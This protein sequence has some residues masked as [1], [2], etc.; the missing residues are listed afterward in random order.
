MKKHLS[1]CA[2]KAGY[3]FSFDNGK[4]FD[5]QDRYKNFG[6][7]LFSIYYDFETTTGGVVFFDVCG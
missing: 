4:I 5:Y 3:I 7:L 2:G 1:M 6:D